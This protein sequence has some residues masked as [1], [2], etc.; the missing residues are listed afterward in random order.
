MEDINR[1]DLILGA[2]TLMAVATAIPFRP[3][4]ARQTKETDMTTTSFAKTAAPE[5]LLAMWKEIDDKTWGK[6]FDC[7]AEDA[8][9]HLG[10]ADWKG[11][12]V[13]RESL[14][15]FVDKQ[16]TTHHDVIEY[17]DG[18]ALKI[19]RGFVTMKFDDP[20]IPTAKPVMTHFFYMDD[21]DPTKVSRWFGSVG[22]VAF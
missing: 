2:G 21:K 19:F 15:N 18:G 9:C 13:I 22:P 5:W 12:E 3:A 14:R 6:G 8:E 4:A 20:S 16:M 1:R 17:W 10:V 11:R 7:F